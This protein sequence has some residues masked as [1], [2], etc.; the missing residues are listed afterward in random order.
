MKECIACGMLMKEK[1][2]FAMGD[3]EKDYCKFCAREDGSMQSYDEKLISLTNFII[4]TQGLEENV[5]SLTAKSM[6]SKL[7]AWNNE[8]ISL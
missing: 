1:E 6:M 5:A 3:I 2:E 8:K 7:K 4:K